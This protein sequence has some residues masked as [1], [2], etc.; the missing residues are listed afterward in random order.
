MVK[1]CHPRMYLDLTWTLLEA[2]LYHSLNPYYLFS[3]QL[4]AICVDYGF[5]P[6]LRANVSNARTGAHNFSCPTSRRNRAQVKWGKAVQCCI[7]QH[8]DLS[9]HNCHASKPSD[10]SLERRGLLRR[11]RWCPSM[12]LAYLPLT[13]SDMALSRSRFIHIK[14]SSGEGGGGNVIEPNE[15]V[16]KELKRVTE[17]PEGC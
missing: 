16:P 3:A 17:G 2:E 7:T 10:G 11:Q 8:G 15:K 6:A 1:I 9:A 4:H 14:K 12:R 5:L 13:L